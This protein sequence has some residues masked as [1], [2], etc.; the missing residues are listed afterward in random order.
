MHSK[1]DFYTTNQGFRLATSIGGTLTGRGGNFIIVDDPI[2][3]GDT[4]SE[5]Q[6]NKVN[7]WYSHTLLSRLDNK[8]EGVIIIVMQRVHENDLTGFL[9]ETDINKE[10]VCINIP[11]IAEKDEEWQLK[12]VTA[13]SFFG[14]T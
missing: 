8:H 7:E 14:I 12:N 6:I 4:F 11:A 9:L 13:E 10:W 2:K 3:P 5:S 1:N